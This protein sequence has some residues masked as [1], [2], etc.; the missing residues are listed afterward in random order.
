[1][2]DFCTVTFTGDQ[3]GTYYVAC[4][5]VKYL[6]SDSLFNTG[7]NSI[8]LY[9]AVNQGQNQTNLTVQALSYPR[10]QIQNYNYTYITNAH[11]ISFNAMAHVYREFDIVSVCLWTLIAISSCLRVIFRG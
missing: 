7:S 5:L 3:G 2:D 1:M 6:D 10:Y 9:P 8:T 11:D 4:N